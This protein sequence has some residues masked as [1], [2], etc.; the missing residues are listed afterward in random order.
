MRICTTTDHVGNV[1]ATQNKNDAK[2]CATCGRP[3]NTA[4]TLH[5]PGTM[6]GD[7]CIRALI[8]HGGFGAVYAAEQR[9][10]PGV[11]LALKE[12]RDPVS[13]HSLEQDSDFTRTLE[14]GAPTETRPSAPP[15]TAIADRCIQ[16][17]TSSSAT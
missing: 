9:Q 5:D 3:L 8:G 12:T 15:D 1:C 10:R 13:I 4:L 7:Y 14:C 6:I 16:S 17:A 11:L 2:F